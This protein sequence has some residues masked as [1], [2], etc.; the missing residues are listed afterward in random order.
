MSIWNWYVNSPVSSLLTGCKN[1][2]AHQ[3][4][5]SLK[6]PINSLENALEKDFNF[7]L[8]SGQYNK[9]KFVRL[10]IQVKIVSLTTYFWEGGGEKKKDVFSF[11]MTI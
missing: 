5:M 2:V 9:I 10:L 6:C 7:N 3:V 4:K 8:S 11:Q 1:H